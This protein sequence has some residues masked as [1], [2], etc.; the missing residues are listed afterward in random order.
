MTFE[1]SLYVA[2]AKFY[3]R[4]FRQVVELFV[5]FNCKGLFKTAVSGAPQSQFVSQTKPPA[6]VLQHSSQLQV[7]A[8]ELRG[9]INV[10]SRKCQR[11]KKYSHLVCIQLKK[12][13][14]G[15]TFWQHCFFWQSF[16]FKG[17][18]LYGHFRMLCQ[19]RNT[20]RKGRSQKCSSRSLSFDVQIAIDC[21]CDLFNFQLRILH[22][23]WSDLFT[24]LW[25]S[26][27]ILIHLIWECI[28]PL[29]AK[30]RKGS[31]Y[32]NIQDLMKF[33]NLKTIIL[34]RL[35]GYKFSY[36]DS[37]LLSIWLFTI[38]YPTCTFRIIAKYL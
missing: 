36:G 11:A 6:V 15:F 2:G 19:Q 37:A 33:N 4:S 27:D 7:I 12:L 13:F 5:A 29:V 17:L 14:S 8:L 31:K 38:S 30:L 23:Q 3:F 21:Y 18:A 24:Q 28:V 16:L 9:L 10:K 20:K 26:A 22:L 35:V 25:L 32:P 34:F 1:I